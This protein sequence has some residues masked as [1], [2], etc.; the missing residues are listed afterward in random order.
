[1][2]TKQIVMK[3]SQIRRRIELCLREIILRFEINSQNVLFSWQFNS[4]S[5]FKASIEVLSY[6]AVS[7]IQTIHVICKN[8]NLII[9]IS[10]GQFWPFVSLPLSK[11][12]DSPHLCRPA[13]AGYVCLSKVQLCTVE[14]VWI[15]PICY[16]YGPENFFPAN[17]HL[18]VS[19]K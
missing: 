9:T 14:L 7:S 17:I 5:Y 12:E 6:W 4:Y 16:M 1:M 3:L 13:H 18:S 19:K 15:W 2:K 10:L 8:F 11:W